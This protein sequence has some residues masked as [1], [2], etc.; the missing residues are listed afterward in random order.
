MWARSVIATK[1]LIVFTRPA[2]ASISGRNVRS[3]NSTWSSAWSAIHTSWSGCN[4][5]FSVCSTAPEPL[6]A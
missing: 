4:R 2:I 6:T 5:G 3:K 1:A